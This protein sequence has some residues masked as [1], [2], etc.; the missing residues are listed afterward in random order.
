MKKLLLLILAL[1]ALT[2]VLVSCGNDTPESTSAISSTSD[3]KTSDNG[4]AGTTTAPHTEVTTTDNNTATV[5]PLSEVLYPDF[6]NPAADMSTKPLWFWN[7]DLA[8]MTTEGVREIVRE[9]YKSGYSGF[10]IL[11]YWQDGYLSDHY[12]ELYEAALDEGAKYGMQ[13]SLYDENGFPSYT[14]GGLFAENYPEL[15]AKRLDMAESAYVKDGKIFLKIPQGTFMGAVA[16]NTE[17]NEMIDISDKAHLVELPE[18]DAA[19]QPVGIMATSVY[20]LAAGYEVD[21]AFDGKLSTRWNALEHSGAGESIIINYGQKTRVDQVK[22]FE[23]SDKELQRVKTVEIQY[24]DLTEN[25]WVTVGSTNKGITDKGADISFEPIDAQ[26]IRIYFKLINGDSASITEI[27]IYSDGQE[28]AKP[29][30]VSSGATED[31]A[32]VGYFSSGDYSDGYSAAKAFD[33]SK[34]SRWNAPNNS[35]SNQWISVQYGKEVTLDSVKI[36]E[37]FSRIRSFSVQYLDG[38]AWKTLATGTTIGEAGKTLTF[39]AVKTTGLRLYIHTTDGQTASIYEFEAYNGETPVR[40]EESNENYKGSYVEYPV[41]G[42]NW[43]LMA[44]V[45]VSEGCIGMDYLSEEA[46]AGFIEITYEE[47][48]KRFKKYF[49]NG[50]ITSAFYDEPS[51]WPAGGLTAYGVQGARMWTDDFNAYFASLYGEEVNPVLY[52]AAMW[53]D[54]GDKTTEARDALMKV[55]TEMFAKNYI[56][57][58]NEWCEEHGL[59]LMGH[60]LFEDTDNPVPL[61]GDLMY[62]FKY[63]SVPTVDVIDR[64]GMTEDYYK[65]ISSS[66]YNWDKALVGVEVYGAMELYTPFTADILYKTAMDLFAKGINTLVPHAVWYDAENNVVYPPELSWRNEKIADELPIYNDYVSR[67]ATLLTQGRHVADIAVLYPIDTLEYDYNFNK[68]YGASA[69]SNY[70]KL[71][72]LLSE[73]LRLDYTYLHPSVLDDSVTVKGNTLHLDNAVNYEDYKVMI[74]PSIRVISLSNL[75]K[76]YAFYQNGGIVISVGS[77]PYLATNSEDSAEVVR[78]ITEMFGLD[79]QGGASQK[80]EKTNAAGGKAYHIATV[81]ELRAV[82]ASAVDTYDVNIEAVNVANGHLTYIHKVVGSRNVYFFAN[83]SSTKVET[84]VTLRGEFEKLE[85]WD[86][87]TGER[88]DLATTVKD[89]N[90][91]FTLSLDK[92][93]SMLVVEPLASE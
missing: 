45:C 88:S 24:W 50:T 67:L 7:T 5:E 62:C 82:M 29:G 27:G 80:A 70:I 32:D 83:S 21:K 86:P 16:W 44:F 65:I 11:P 8:S 37:A 85:L 54:I 56:G 13:F 92:V 74:L 77:L 49:D 53:Y 33:G 63:Q 39:E 72:E 57:Q 12:F 61:E 68:G 41:S 20:S 14:A 90:T 60:M 84:T 4:A 73:T 26:Y 66:A 71:T 15:T 30:F 47:Y 43:K 91:T 2:A 78:I 79:P 64:Y 35:S 22:L 38:T 52:Y 93:T 9:C 55:R 31:G 46:V 81:N 6:Q 69:D 18:F 23:A 36:Y 25:K 87:M 3:P 51:F 34:G 42:D 58:L 10:G 89:G 17:T 1:L 28:V 75:E 76:I 48:Y 59:A 40:Y 19:A